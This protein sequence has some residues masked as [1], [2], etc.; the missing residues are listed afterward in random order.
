[1]LLHRP[2][3][4]Y[5]TAVYR[6]TGRRSASPPC[7]RFCTRAGGHR[8]SGAHRAGRAAAGHGRRRTLT[9][10]RFVTT[11]QEV[12][13]SSPAERASICAAQTTYSVLSKIAINLRD[14]LG[15]PIDSSSP[16]PC[17]AWLHMAGGSR[18]PRP[19]AAWSTPARPTRSRR[20]SAVSNGGPRSRNGEIRPRPLRRAGRVTPGS[21]RP[22]GPRRTHLTP[23]APARPAASNT[24]PHQPLRCRIG[25]SWIKLAVRPGPRDTAGGLRPSSVARPSETARRQLPIRRRPSWRPGWRTWL[26]ASPRRRPGA[27][28]PR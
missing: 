13:G 12:A 28:S 16:W 24:A 9:N 1:M 23:T 2:W 10:V 19:V 8:R 17:A 22:R 25:R 15:P 5:R 6:P 18:R 26:S 21:V 20:A 11:D 3:A 4:A 7:T 27:R 14:D